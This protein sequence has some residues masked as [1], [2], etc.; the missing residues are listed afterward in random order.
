MCIQCYRQ[1][2]IA[3]TNSDFL[4]IVVFN[5]FGYLKLRDKNTVKVIVKMAKK[6]IFECLRINLQI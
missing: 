6:V 1:L 4:L 5:I 2:L 3:E